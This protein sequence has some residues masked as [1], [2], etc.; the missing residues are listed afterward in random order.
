MKRMKTLLHIVN[1]CN[2]PATCLTLAASTCFAIAAGTQPPQDTSATLQ[3]L[4]EHLDQQTKRV[5]RRYRALGPP[6][7]EAEESA[8]AMKKQQEEG[9]AFAM[10]PLFRAEDQNF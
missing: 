3:R 4:Q 6:M 2:L 8:A 9:T 10:K 5:D 7:A 1:R